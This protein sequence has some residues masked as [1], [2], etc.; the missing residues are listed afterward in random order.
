MAKWKDKRER[1]RENKRRKEM[2]NEKKERERE[3]CCRVNKLL[4]T[5]ITIKKG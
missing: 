5:T 4:G 1:K 3:R 2:N